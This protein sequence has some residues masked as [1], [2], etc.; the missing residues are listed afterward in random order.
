MSRIARVFLAGCLAILPLVMTGLALGWLVTFLWDIVGP[1]TG[2]GRLLTS[3]GGGVGASAAPYI[4]GILL[5]VAAIYALGLLV[6][7]RLGPWL[8]SAFDRLARRI[9]IVA[10]VYDVT[11]RFTAIV[12]TKDT[13][14]IK[15]MRPVWCFFGGEPG[16]AVLAL[17]PSAAPTV[18]G[19]REYL[20]V[21]VP[22]APV[23]VG[24]ALIYVP[25]EWI[26]PAEG[27]VDELLTVYLSMGVTPPGAGRP[28]RS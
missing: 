11:R 10:E 16:A 3:L 21:L 12:D 2:F 9:P 1:S 4:V 7:S 28:G 14:G 23:P 5:L 22:S 25:S 24:G 27:G 13:G 6:E 20:G 18:I 15:S 8:V 19:G 26:R 17:V